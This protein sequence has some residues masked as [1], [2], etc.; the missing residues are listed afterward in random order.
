MEVRTGNA[1]LVDDETMGMD[2]FPIGLG[3]VEFPNGNL[4]EVATDA[5][6]V[7]ERPLTSVGGIRAAVAVGH[8]LVEGA[9]LIPLEEPVIEVDPAAVE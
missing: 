6:A 8:A 1:P 2:D 5:H 3:L 7:R 9:L 4:D